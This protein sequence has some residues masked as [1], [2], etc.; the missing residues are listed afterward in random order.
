MKK[1]LFLAFMISTISLIGC[2][3]KETLLDADKIPAEIK[4]YVEKHFPGKNILQCIKDVD[5]LEVSYDVVVE[6][7]YKLE[8]NRDKK[9]DSVKGVSKLPDSVVPEKILAYVASNYPGNYI[10]E[11]DADKTTQ[12]VKLDNRLELV[13]NSAGDF[14]RIDD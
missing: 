13:F 5:G 1:I 2:D 7:G 8:F 4:T 12:E 14:L 3:D 11:W 10:I 9:I 6:G